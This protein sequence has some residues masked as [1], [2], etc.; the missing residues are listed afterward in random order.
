MGRIRS[1]SLQLFSEYVAKTER[2]SDTF[3][4]CLS[5]VLLLV[6]E[7]LLTNSLYC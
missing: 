4:D 7:L 2:P 1:D 6:D 5:I 3:D